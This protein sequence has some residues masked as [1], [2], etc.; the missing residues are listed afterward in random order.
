MEQGYKQE[1]VRVSMVTPV[2]KHALDHL[3]K[4]ELVVHQ[5]VSFDS[6]ESVTRSSSVVSLLSHE[7]RIWCF[8]DCYLFVFINDKIPVEIFSNSQNLRICEISLTEIISRIFIC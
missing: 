4:H 5:L 1:D 7:I 6:T 2:V 8:F 3:P